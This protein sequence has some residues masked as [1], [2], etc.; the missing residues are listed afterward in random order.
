MLLNVAVDGVWYL[1]DVAFGAMTPTAPLR[2]DTQDEQRTPH[3]PYRLTT[4]GNARNL[5]VKL[6]KNWRPVYSFDDMDHF[7]V[8]FEAVNWQVSTHPHS[9]FVN[10]L[11]VART[12]E[13]RRQILTNTNLAVRHSDGRVEKSVLNS[14]ADLRSLLTQMFGIKLP[15]SVAVDRAFGRL[16]CTR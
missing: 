2:L 16:F 10:N 5:E 8:D 14:E 15:A 12:A 13:D 6:G 11:I 9:E 7:P 3:Q 4:D 1:C